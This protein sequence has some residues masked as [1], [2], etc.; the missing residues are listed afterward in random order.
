MNS[1]K[2]VL[3]DALP[4]HN[5]VE[6]MIKLMLMGS[7]QEVVFY[8]G[9]NF[10][11]IFWKAYWVHTV[12]PKSRDNFAEK[13][14]PAWLP[15]QIPSQ[16]TQR[17][18]FWGIMCRKSTPKNMAAVYCQFLRKAALMPIVSRRNGSGKKKKIHC[19]MTCSMC[20]MSTRPNVPG[21]EL[22]VKFKFCSLFMLRQQDDSSDKHQN[23][24][25][26]LL[27]SERAAQSRFQERRLFAMESTSCRHAQSR[28]KHK[29]RLSVLMRP[30]DFTWCYSSR[31]AIS[32]LYM[33]QSASLWKNRCRYSL[34]LCT[35]N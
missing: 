17:Q 29:K 3:V 9:L 22:F 32:D 34:C 16:N 4:V 20:N 24:K 23:E 7:C 2:T 30:S 35:V 18:V 10:R 5:T 1:T 33:Q 28:T 6:C 8:L 19:F 31:C 13:N 14:I 25:C 27:R 11:R 15:A 21:K 26:K 12:S